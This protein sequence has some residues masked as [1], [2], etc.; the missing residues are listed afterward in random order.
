MLFIGPCFA[1]IGGCL[2]LVTPGATGDSGAEAT[3]MA[4]AFMTG[5]F[6]AAGLLT[7]ASMAL[8]GATAAGTFMAFMVRIAF[9]LAIAVFILALPFFIGGIASN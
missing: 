9:G 8:A 2:A 5:D 3:F 1:F 7:G 4:A 6:I